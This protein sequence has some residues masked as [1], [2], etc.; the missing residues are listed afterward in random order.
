MSPYWSPPA[1]QFARDIRH[2]NITVLILD[3]IGVGL[4]GG[5]TNRRVHFYLSGELALRSNAGC[6]RFLRGV[7]AEVFARTAAFQA[8]L[9]AATT[10]QFRVSDAS[11]SEMVNPLPGFSRPPRQTLPVNADVTAVAEPDDVSP[12]QAAGAE[13]AA[14][15]VPQQD[16]YTD[17]GPKAAPPCGGGFS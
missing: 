9:T 16:V 6:V 17:A 14:V 12:G 10:A 15:A 3:Y 4:S 11:H 13:P 1:T 5:Y 8:R 7:T 2:A